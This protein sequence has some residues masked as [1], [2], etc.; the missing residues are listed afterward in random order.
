MTIP[1]QLE[2]V[3][4]GPQDI[5]I[6]TQDG[7]SVVVEPVAGGYVQVHW[8]RPG[9]RSWTITLDRRNARNLSDAL[10]WAAQQID[11]A[12]PDPETPLTG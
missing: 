9:R 1:G 12:F 10:V 4:H 8:I 3:E 6:A 2:P 7:G 5:Q 11:R